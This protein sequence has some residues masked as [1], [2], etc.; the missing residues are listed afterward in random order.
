MTS[1]PLMS[2]RVYEKLYVRLEA[3]LHVLLQHVAA[4]KKKKKK[5]SKIDRLSVAIKRALMPAWEKRARHVAMSR[6]GS[7]NTCDGSL[8]KKKRRRSRSD[9]QIIRKVF[10]LL[11]HELPPE[12]HGN[13]G[14][15]NKAPGSCAPLV[16]SHRNNNALNRG[17]FGKLYLNRTRKT[18][19]IVN[20][21]F[22][23]AS[24]LVKL[25]VYGTHHL[26][27]KRQ[28]ETYTNCMILVF[29]C[30]VSRKRGGG[31]FSS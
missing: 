29:V 2:V 27:L 6:S 13:S 4:E 14:E 15:K 23:R 3:T 26:F 16:P 22:Q 12:L 9:S 24:A 11:D 17:C 1:L 10:I 21:D 7:W 5:P 20:P 25:Y 8:S 18:T 19:R 31:D 30:V 28:R